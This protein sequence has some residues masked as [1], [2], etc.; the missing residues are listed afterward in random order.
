MAVVPLT[1]TISLCLAF[2]FVLFF[3][4]E[5][6]RSR[7]SGTESEALLP[8]ADEQA[9]TPKEGGTLDLGNRMPAR[10]RKP[11][12]SHH[13]EHDHGDSERCHGCERRDGSCQSHS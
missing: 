4:R 12:G 5:H 3:W 10:R 7:F 13:H 1:L 6:S 2:T 9:R 11:C 8:L